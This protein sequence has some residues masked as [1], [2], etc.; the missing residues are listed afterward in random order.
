MVHAAMGRN[1]RGLQVVPEGH[2][3]PQ[4]AVYFCQGGPAAGFGSG[5]ST[6]RGGTSE[7]PFNA[8]VAP[9]GLPA[10]SLTGHKIA[11]L[12]QVLIYAGLGDRDGTFD[13]LDRMIELGP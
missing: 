8:A 3:R 1:R 7:N 9:P 4:H 6:L 10:A 11:A 12:Q 5:G 13:A 2:R